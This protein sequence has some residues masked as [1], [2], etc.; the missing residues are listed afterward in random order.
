MT[1]GFPKSSGTPLALTGDVN[2]LV[3]TQYDEELIAAAEASRCRQAGYPR[4]LPNVEG[5]LQKQYAGDGLR[6]ALVGGRDR[7]SRVG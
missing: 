7:Q 5:R 3:T 6:S 1:A 4:V 2:P